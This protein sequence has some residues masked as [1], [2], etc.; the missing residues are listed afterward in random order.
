ML[1]DNLSVATNEHKNGTDITTLELDKGT[2]EVTNKGTCV[3]I[4]DTTGSTYLDDPSPLLYITLDTA[5]IPE[6]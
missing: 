1:K 2:H 4:G 6:E 3:V 5:K